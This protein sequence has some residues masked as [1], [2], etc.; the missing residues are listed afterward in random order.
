M[1][2]VIYHYEQLTWELHIISR[3][4]SP[5]LNIEFQ[6]KKPQQGRAYQIEQQPGEPRASRQGRISAGRNT[7]PETGHG[8]P[9]TKQGTQ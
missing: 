9:L 6:S 7:A 4:S 5:Y 1:W 2:N 8:V 3:H